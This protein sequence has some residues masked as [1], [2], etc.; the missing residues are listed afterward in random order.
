MSNLEKCN[1]KKKKKTRN[2]K[3]FKKTK[4]DTKR[5]LQG[6]YRPPPSPRRLK[7][8]FFFFEKKWYKKSCGN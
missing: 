5:G 1:F 3:V 6:V 8:M 7:V 4:K 2:Q